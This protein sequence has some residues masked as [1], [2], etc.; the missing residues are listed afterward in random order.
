MPRPI[1]SAAYVET[2][3]I[4]RLARFAFYGAGIKTVVTRYANLELG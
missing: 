3:G 4:V 2:I 1:G